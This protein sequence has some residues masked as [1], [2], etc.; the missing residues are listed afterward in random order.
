M[1]HSLLPLT[2]PLAFAA[3]IVNGANRR[4]IMRGQASALMIWE[5]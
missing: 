2:I 1:V 5:R 3:V 4:C